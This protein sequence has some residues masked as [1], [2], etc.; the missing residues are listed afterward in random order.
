MSSASVRSSAPTDS[1]RDFL[2]DPASVA[3]REDSDRALASLDSVDEPI[4]P[5]PVLPEPFEIPPKRFADRG[6][7]GQRAQR[8]FD[9]SL[10]LWRQVTNHLGHVGWYVDAPDGHYFARRFGGTS[11]SPNTSSNDR[12]RWP[13][14]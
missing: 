10:D 11:R 9:P 13:P 7:P 8:R 5:D 2:V 12:P 4:P 14:A 3:Y 1:R 6:I